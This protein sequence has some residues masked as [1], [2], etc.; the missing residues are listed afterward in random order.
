MG[1]KCEARR[2]VLGSVSVVSCLY[3]VRAAKKDFAASS[4][5]SVEWTVIAKWTVTNGCVTVNKKFCLISALNRRERG[6]LFIPKC[7]L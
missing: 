5:R 3:C 2:E 1:A 6:G 4:H 7:G